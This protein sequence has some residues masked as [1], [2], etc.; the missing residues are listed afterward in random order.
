MATIEIRRQEQKDAEAL[1]DLYS[2]PKVVRGTLQLPY[3]SLQLWET[4]VAEEPEGAICL[5]ACIDERVVGNIAL[6]TVTSARRRHTGEFGMAVHDNWQGKG[7]GHALLAAAL[8]LADNWLDL[9]RIELQVFADN[10]PARRLY[11]R[12][13]FEIEGTFKR[14]AFREGEYADVYAMA[15]LRGL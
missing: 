10:E 13:G 14:Y 2:Q 8:D 11:E 3:P 4:R 9:R 5:V 1:R 15:R 12:C 7:C 6:W